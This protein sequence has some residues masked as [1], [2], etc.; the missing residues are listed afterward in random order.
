MNYTRK[1]IGSVKLKTEPQPVLERF[2]VTLLSESK[3]KDSNLRS[4]TCCDNIK[5]LS[6]SSKLWHTKE[7]M[8]EEKKITV[9]A[10]IRKQASK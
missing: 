2:S 7:K 6:Q 10:M 3:L 5:H 1:T 4:E 8:Q 9:I